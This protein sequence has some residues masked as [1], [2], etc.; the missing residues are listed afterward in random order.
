MARLRRS[1]LAS[2]AIR[3]VLPGLLVAAVPAHAAE[4]IGVAAAVANRVTGT[5][6]TDM[7]TLKVGDGVF[8]DETID[9]AKKST[10]QLLFRDETTLTIGPNSSVVLHT[11]VYDPETNT[12]RVVLNTIKG[13]FRFITGSVDVSAYQIKT[14][15]ASIG[16]RGS[17]FDWFFDALG[18]LVVILV[19]GALEICNAAGQCV[20]L[21]T[22]GTYVLVGPDSMTEPDDWDGTIKAIAFGVT[23]P[24]FG[25]RYD[26][27]KW[28]P[29]DIP[30][31]QRDINT[32]I[33]GLG[34]EGVEDGNG[35]GDGESG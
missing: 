29:F 33:D 4:D 34:I 22:P 6:G 28:V 11:F 23:F 21:D 35:D 10:A 8:Q 24:L 27:D 3:L 19:E 2:T 30:Y 9:T 18:R 7:R 13:A 15:F 31:D 32:A 16:V 14:P 5:L 26:G 20:V 17:I 1:L 12:G 25:R